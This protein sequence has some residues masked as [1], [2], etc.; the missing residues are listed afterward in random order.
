M[1]TNLSDYVKNYYFASMKLDS[2]SEVLKKFLKD[3]ESG[4]VVESYKSLV[5][6]IQ[7]NVDDK[8]YVNLYF[9]LYKVD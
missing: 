1:T 8:K 3:L 7:K 4:S 5:D 6:Y 2:E 9:N